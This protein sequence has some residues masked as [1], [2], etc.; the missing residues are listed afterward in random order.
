MADPLDLDT[1]ER[2][3]HPP[4]SPFADYCSGCFEPWPCQTTRLV[5][6]V[7]ELEAENARQAD[8]LAAAYDALA[9]TREA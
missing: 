1:I 7:R 3:H 5:W 4:P 6:R 8:E 9:A 2:F